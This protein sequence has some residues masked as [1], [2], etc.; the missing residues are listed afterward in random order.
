MQKKVTL[1]LNS[2]V[3]RDFQSFCEKRALMLSKKIELI[4][5][6]ILD[7]KIKNEIINKPIKSKQQKVTLSIDG[8]IYS[9]F[10][11]YCEDRALMLSKKIELIM[12]QLMEAT[13]SL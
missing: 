10:Q 3:Y 8:K 9:D 11:E 1:S 13:G 7:D 4:M 6:D 2:A 12:V 5:K